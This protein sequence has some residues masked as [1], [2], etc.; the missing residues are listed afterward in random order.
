MWLQ[1]YGI[2]GMSR[3]IFFQD[4]PIFPRVDL[5]R[6][7]IARG[8]RI[9]SQTR[10]QA[11]ACLPKAR[12]LRRCQLACWYLTEWNHQP[13]IHAWVLSASER[14]F[15]HA[16][17][18]SDWLDQK[19]QYFGNNFCV[20]DLRPVKPYTAGRGSL[21]RVQRCMVLL[22]A[23]QRHKSYSRN[24]APSF[25]SRRFIPK[26]QYS[27]GKLWAFPWVQLYCLN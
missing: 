22:A 4:G 5:P 19:V 18:H 14:S 9:R 13:C 17:L 26:V 15:F 23:D 11:A 16:W 12:I 25:L 21:S 1:L 24:I 7:K 6:P 20:F 3:L 27:K 8:I 2:F 10:Q